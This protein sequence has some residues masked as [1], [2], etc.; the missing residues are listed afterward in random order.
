MIEQ[1][2]YCYYYIGIYIFITHIVS[3]FI[4]ARFFYNPEDSDTDCMP[5][6]LFLVGSIITPIFLIFGLIGG[7]TLLFNYIGRKNTTE[8][9]VIE[10]ESWQCT[11]CNTL[12]K[13]GANRC[14]TCGAPVIS[15][16]LLT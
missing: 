13:R 5:V 16:K 2:T 11:Y 4:Y 3:S 7:L 1:H 15:N 14:M 12:N 10:E 8:E 9:D 6:M